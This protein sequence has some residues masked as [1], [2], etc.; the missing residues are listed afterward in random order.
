[1]IG[2][3]L[4]NT[5]SDYGSVSRGICEV[6][7]NNYMTSIIERTEIKKDNNS[8]IFKE[9]SD[10]WEKLSGSEIVSMNLFA[11]TPRVFK[12]YRQSF[13]SFLMNHGNDLKSEFYLPSVVDELIKS[14]EGKVK[15]IET[16]EQWFGLTYKEDKA[17]VAERISQ[18]VKQGKYPSKLW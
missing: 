14:K 15:I 10:K 18:L 2:Y 6:D 1:L 7:E 9:D 11:F 16:D 3:K 4:I 8:I 17:I 12:N 5:L 13:N